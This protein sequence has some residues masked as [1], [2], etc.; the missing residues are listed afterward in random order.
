M[1]PLK[2]SSIAALDGQAPNGL[3]V[4]TISCWEVAMLHGNGRLVFSR[5]LDQWFDEAFRYPGVHAV[6]VSREI[7]VD[8]C[9]LPGDFHRDPADRI[10]V[11]T[12]R[13]LDI[14][15][16]TAD[17]RILSYKNVDSIHPNAL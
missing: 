1:A 6:D 8:S 5:P 2:A 7:L 9:R 17:K 3:S 13:A 11:A 14:P 10:L 4:S 16:V 12:A 15:L